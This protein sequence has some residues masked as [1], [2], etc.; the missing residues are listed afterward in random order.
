MPAISL[1]RTFL[2]WMRSRMAAAQKIPSGDFHDSA[3]RTPVSR[4]RV[5]ARMS[6]CDDWNM[7]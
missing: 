3:M 7:A 6:C 4:W 2:T 1:S 5:D